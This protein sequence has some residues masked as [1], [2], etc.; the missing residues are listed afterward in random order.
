MKPLPIIY[1]KT[2]NE[3]ELDANKT[4]ELFGCIGNIDGIAMRLCGFECKGIAQGAWELTYTFERLL[5]PFAD[6]SSLGFT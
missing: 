2:V 6:F 3:S 1:K 4:I 5:Y